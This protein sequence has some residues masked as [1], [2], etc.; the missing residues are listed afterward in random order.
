MAK[1]VDPTVG[2]DVGDMLPDE[3]TGRSRRW[4]VGLLA[5]LVGNTIYLLSLPLLPVAA[6]M[7]AGSGITIPGLVDLCFCTFVFGLLSLPGLSG[8]PK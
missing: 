3:E 4:F 2:R 5:I 1:G 8:K 6:R 7:G